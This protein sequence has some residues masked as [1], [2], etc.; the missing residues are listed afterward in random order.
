M[1]EPTLAPTKLGL[2][3]HQQ[4]HPDSDVYHLSRAFDL[5]D[6]ADVAALDQ[7][8]RQVVHRHPS[9]RT[10]YHPGPV[11]PL[12][13]EQ[14]VPDRLLQVEDLDATGAETVDD[15]LLRIVRRPFALQTDL[16]ARFVVV[17]HRHDGAPASRVFVAVIHHIALDLTGLGILVDDLS[18][19][20]QAAL[21]AP[22][23]SAGE[24]PPAPDGPVVR[25]PP[26]PD[27]DP[28]DADYWRDQLNRL[29]PP[30]R[31]PHRHDGA[32]TSYRGAELVRTLSPE[33]AGR[34]AALAR[35]RQTTPYVLALALYAISLWRATGEAELCLGTPVRVDPKREAIDYNLN[36][37]A[38]RVALPADQ[39][40]ATLVR[41]VHGTVREALRHRRLPFPDVVAQSGLTAPPGQSP[42]FSTMIVAEAVSSTRRIAGV[43]MGTGS[44]ATMELGP[45]RLQQRPLSVT[46]TSFDLTLRFTTD[47]LG[48]QYRCDVIDPAVVADVADRFESALDEFAADPDRPLS[49]RP[50]VDAAHGV[51]PEV[52]EPPPVGS[53]DRTTPDRPP[54]HQRVLAQ[55]QQTPDRPAVRA[56]GA[57]VSY[58]ELA[59]RVWTVATRLRRLGAGR[60]VPVA[61]AASATPDA[62]VAL[63]AVLESG[64]GYAALDPELPTEQLAERVRQLQ[65]PVVLADDDHQAAL[66]DALGAGDAAGRSADRGVV[67]IGLDGNGAAPDASADA[68]Q[69]GA[70]DALVYPDQLA[71]VMFTSGSTA[72][73]KGVMVSHRQ[74]SA[75]TFD[76]P[77]YFRD[78]VGRFLLVSRL[79]FDSSVAGLFRTLTEGGCLVL[80]D[81]ERAHDPAHHLQLLAEERITHFE[82]V[83]PLYQVLLSR[84]EPGALTELRSVVVAGEA[85]PPALVR[86]H[87]TVL[88]DVSFHNE[89]GPTEATVWCAAF[90]APP[91]WDGPAVPIG[92]AIPSARLHVLDEGGQPR[93]VGQGELFVGGAVVSRGYVG[94]PAATA[95][96][97]LPDPLSGVPGAR[98]Y[99]TGDLVR[100]GP[101]DD[102][103]FVGRADDQVKLRGYRIELTAVQH[104]LVALADVTDA[105]ATVRDDF[106]G[107]PQLVAYLVPRTGAELRP[108]QLRSALLRTLPAEQV[109]SVFCAVDQLPL[110]V[111][112]KLDRAR[113]PD[114]QATALADHAGEPPRDHYEQLV[115]EEFRTALNISTLGRADNFFEAGGS[116][117]QAM[118]TVARIRTA[119]RV[120]LS[121]GALFQAPVAADLAAQLRQLSARSDPDE[122][123]PGEGPVPASYA[124]QRLWFIDQLIPDS[125]AYNIPIALRLRGPIDSDLMAGVLDAVYQ[126]HD[127]LRTVFPGERGQPHPTVREGHIEL[128]R[129]TARSLTEAVDRARQAATEPFD[130]AA[131][132][133]LRGRLDRI[134]PDDHVL[135]LVMHHIVSDGWSLGVLTDEVC[136]LYAAGVAGRDPTLPELPVQFA[137]FARWQQR[138]A[139]RRDHD[140]QLEWW[141]E[142]LADPPTLQLPTDRP[143]PSVQTFAGRTFWWSLPREAT[144]ALRTVARDHDAS[145]FML[146][147]AGFA[148]LLRR[149]CYSEDLIVGTVVS[150]RT[151]PSTE[152][153]VGLFANTAP[154]RLD[155]S[156]EPPIGELIDRVRRAAAD[157]FDH[158][159]VPFERVVERLQ[160]H[161]DLSQNPV[162]QVVFAYQN[163]PR[164]P[165]ELPGVAAELL[166]VTSE[167]AKFDLTASVWEEDGRLRGTFE[168]SS[169]IFDPETIEL[170]WQRYREL[171]LAFAAAPDRGVDELDWSS[172][173]AHPDPDTATVADGPTL[174]PLD[175]VGRPLAPHTI[176]Q[177][178][179]RTDDG[180]LLPTGEF[181]Q[182]ADD[183]GW[184]TLARPAGGTTAGTERADFRPPSN[185]IETVLG[186]LWREL[187]PGTGSI[188]VDDD[189]FGLG[190]HSLLATRVAAA[191]ESVFQTPVSLQAFFVQPTV[192]GLASQVESSERTP[193]EAATI[194]SI[195]LRVAGEAEG[196]V[197]QEQVELADETARSG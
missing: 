22:P 18:A 138:P 188:G 191:A 132:P 133:L 64:S 26:E 32:G 85:C 57:S 185:D 99:R 13:Q 113:L 156:G 146:T 79:S 101:N 169:A 152:P 33:Q 43:A 116:S 39:P 141:I 29:P 165:V 80:P 173:A 189:F 168:Y 100:S 7:A 122:L 160:N 27:P 147:L 175:I 48:W 23:P 104:A 16:P 171:L 124:Q 89:Y 94:Q 42:V 139:V 73:P 137:D 178:H 91:D 53:P 102:L 127:S 65:T 135:T 6:D 148:T 36:T 10:T 123:A 149:L 45:L 46:S 4:A 181:A 60:E 134:A 179:V 8:L 19:A 166:D 78:T 130:L 131:G 177:L 75:S 155:L 82:S 174:V 51:V 11:L 145:M 172:D 184:A 150:G 140:E 90:T 86:A 44:E 125:A 136:E 151:H 52:P 49:A 83:P 117:L 144:S 20:Y 142:R 129:A 159:T 55:A 106:S 35:D 112:G 170:F 95:A 161:R 114:P 120:E 87:Q 88:P 121:D 84:L 98:M 164:P 50:D 196:P 68:P 67:V 115:V 157:A 182:L 190:G 118:Q 183:G 186:Q 62:V 194:A 17:E 24:R 15:A 197:E 59:A 76:R 96:A 54:V 167:T 21:D 38:I 58:G 128:V 143:R 109:P 5:P 37:V 126:R 92:R 107:V 34:L 108:S 111:N 61:V 193:G 192:A 40:F 70:A 81:P 93:P 162:F 2:W 158:Q 103:V 180:A 63:L 9:L 47:E 154:I 12:G 69:P 176:G 3:A 97:F 105:A 30:L 74:L 153:L 25:L 71:Y 119:A 14:P 31:L 1:A 187:L 72:Q 77:D 28:S 56:G 66:R 163:A 195:W 110:T 41:T